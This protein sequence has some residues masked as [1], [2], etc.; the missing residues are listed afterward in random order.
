M[1]GDQ[2]V[3]IFNSFIIDFKLNKYS[4][5]VIIAFL[6]PAILALLQIVLLIFIFRQETPVQLY[7]TGKKNLCKD[8]LKKIY[9]IPESCSIAYGDIESYWKLDTIKYPTYTE[10]SS[11][12]LIKNT[13]KG[14]SVT[15]IREISGAFLAT[16]LISLV[17]TDEEDLIDHLDNIVTFVGLIGSFIPFFLLN[18][19]LSSYL[20]FWDKKVISCWCYWYSSDKGDY[21]GSNIVP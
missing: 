12:E 2:I 6:M 5:T 9:K 1:I 8:E 4:L 19:I 18:S 10:L 13:L 21:A 17:F 7:R 20:S 16:I 11:P 15:M 3:F 14:I